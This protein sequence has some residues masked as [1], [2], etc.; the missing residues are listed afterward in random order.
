[1]GN[2]LGT[3]HND[4]LER[5]I[6][7]WLISVKNLGICKKRGASKQFCGSWSA[8]SIQRAWRTTSSGVQR[9]VPDTKS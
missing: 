9:A 4:D 2:E 5:C 7:H 3:V 6:H 1:M 8:A